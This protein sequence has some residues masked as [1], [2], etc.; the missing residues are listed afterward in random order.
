MTHLLYQ[1]RDYWKW[2]P[3]VKIDF[4]EFGRAVVEGREYTRDLIIHPDRVDDSW[5]RREGH[6][7]H[8][9]DLKQA[10]EGSPE[11]LVVGTGYY[12]FMKISRETED[13][14]EKKGVKLIAQKTGE[15]V[16]IYNELAPRA[17]VVAAL[18]LTC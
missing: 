8:V 5:W 17:R 14:L 1:P 6:Q 16:R 7:L 10:V 9:E 18:H 15:A 2:S 4:Y 3:V 13:F 11:V 12:G